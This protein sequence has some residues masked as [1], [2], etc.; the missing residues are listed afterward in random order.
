MQVKNS[1]MSAVKRIFKFTLGIAGVRRADALLFTP[2]TA[3][4]TIA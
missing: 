4:V 1:F 2:F 3:L